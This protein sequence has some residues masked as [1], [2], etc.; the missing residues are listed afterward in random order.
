MNSGI[1][2]VLL[3]LLG[4]GAIS[5][6]GQQLLPYDLIVT[7]RDVNGWPLNPRWGAQQNDVKS[8]PEWTACPESAP[9]KTGC[10]NSPHFTDASALKCPDT[11]FEH[12]PFP[13]H[14]NFGAVVMTGKVAW[15]N[16]SS[17]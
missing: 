6:N 9:W 16:H 4:L 13:G 11:A 17:N 8:L 15:S 10:S 14:V 7:T 5:A 1:K 12:V 2:L 3:M